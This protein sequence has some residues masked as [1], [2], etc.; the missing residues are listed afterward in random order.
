[1]WAVEVRTGAFASSDARGLAEFTRRNPRYR[2]LLLSD[3][4]QLQAAR[5]TGIEALAW[6]QFLL[7]GPPS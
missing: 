7:A 2:P 4:E 6:D 1:M 5:R 3:P